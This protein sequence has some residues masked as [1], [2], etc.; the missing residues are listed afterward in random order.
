MP[1][2]AHRRKRVL[3]ACE[4]SNTVRDAFLQ[5]GHDAYSCDLLP[6]EHPNTNWRR[7]IRGDVRPLLAQQ[8]DL[9][10]AHPPCTHLCNSGVWLL[11]SQRKP[12]EVMLEAARFFNECLNANARMVC[13][14]N[15]IMHCYARE[16]VGVDYSQIVQPY[17]FGHPFTKQTCLWLRGLPLLQ[18]T[19]ILENKKEYICAKLSSADS[20]ERSR[21]FQGIA[22]AMASQWGVL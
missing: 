4:W 18:P 15:P 9:V 7:H 12:F 16:A 13:V 10:I 17:Q 1:L 5:L 11:T 19:N 21:T 22:S 2:P 8:W 3:V 6:A 20:K 14:E